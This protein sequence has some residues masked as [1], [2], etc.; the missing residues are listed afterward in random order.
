MT[1]KQRQRLLELTPNLRRDALAHAKAQADLA[2]YFGG[3]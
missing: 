2:D 1:P 3:G